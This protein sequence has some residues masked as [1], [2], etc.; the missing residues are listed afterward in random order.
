MAAKNQFYMYPSQSQKYKVVWLVTNRFS[1]AG[2]DA[3][4]VAD[5]LKASGRYPLF[6]A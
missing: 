1:E 5:Q 2:T 4:T 6:I 3:E